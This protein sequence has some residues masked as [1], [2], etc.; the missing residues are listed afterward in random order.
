M[1]QVVFL[2]EVNRFVAGKTTLLDI[3]VLDKRNRVEADI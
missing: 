3:G 2:Q 1:I